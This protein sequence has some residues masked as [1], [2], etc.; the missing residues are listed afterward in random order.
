MKERILYDCGGVFRR[1]VS[2]GSRLQCG[3]V[4]GHDEYEG[5]YVRKSALE[6]EKTVSKGTTVAKG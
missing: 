1:G 5:V 4:A 3:W 2:A 6:A